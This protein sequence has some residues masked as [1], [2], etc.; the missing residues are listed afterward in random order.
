MHFDFKKKTKKI[1][2][3]SLCLLSLLFT[4]PKMISFGVSPKE[5]SILIT[6]NAKINKDNIFQL[7]YTTN[8][9]E[10]F[11]RENNVSVEV[12]KEDFFQDIVFKLNQENINKLRIDFGT[13]PNKVLVKHIIINNGKNVIKL[14]P[15]DVL[16]LF[17][18]I[19]QLDSIRISDKYLVIESNQI[20]PFIF[21]AKSLNDIINDSSIN[22]NSDHKF[23]VLYLGLFICFYG[24]V[25]AIYNSIIN[26]KIKILSII[27]IIT[28]MIVLLFP[29][30]QIFLNFEKNDINLEKRQLAPKP[31]LA[32]HG[33]INKNFITEF[34][35]YYTDNF[36]F[37]TQLIKISSTIKYKLLKTSSVEDVI[38]GKQ[39][40]LF[41]SQEIPDFKG[42]NLFST[43][44]LIIIKDHL[45]EQKK[46]LEARGIEYIFMVAPNKSSIYGDY[47][48]TY[49]KEKQQYKRI[50][51]V[52][53][54]LKKQTDIKVIDPRKE[55]LSNKYRGNLY[56]KTDTH[57]NDLG[58]FVAYQELM[59]EIRKSFPNIHVS[60]L[61]DYSIE[62]NIY[63]GKDLAVMMYLPELQENGVKLVRPNISYD[64]LKS[65]KKNV[66]LYINKDTTLPSAVFLRDSFTFAME[67]YLGN[68]FSK[69]VY[70][71]YLDFDFNTELII[72]EKPDIVVFEIV[73]RYLDKILDEELQR[74][75]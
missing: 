58:A 60:K 18:S 55:L 45:E 24:I 29:S 70:D 42:N 54:F 37:R 7:F 25:Q 31:K 71:D 33:A 73:E 56:Y 39:N 11:T 5:E 65:D 1:F 44:E 75:R 69:V 22:N 36:G 8:D 27:S 62:K 40:W 16:S 41:Y 35:K 59:Q 47:L 66:S 2:L 63:R 57:W 12:K 4:T 46:W 51:Q 49:I 34:Q 20:D 38:I 3:L 28:F 74:V 14:K 17:S 26:N 32:I 67:P 53:D 10:Q 21:S 50:D 43:D 68:S 15:E 52:V 72:N 19:N 9:D 48:P 13:E 23:I 30:F 64:L 61:G 6:I